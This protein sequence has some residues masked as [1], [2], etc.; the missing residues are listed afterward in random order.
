MIKIAHLAD[1]HF[2][3]EKIE[4][5]NIAL[6]SFRDE[7]RKNLVDLI[8]ISGDIWDGAVQ[9]TA[10][11]MFPFFVEHIQSLADIA[12]VVMIY[13]TPSH[14]TEGSLEVFQKIESE[15]GISILRPGAAYVLANGDVYHV[16]EAPGEK[17]DLLLF[18]VPEPS[19]KWLLANS[20]AVG[21]EAAAD[22]AAQ[23]L[24]NLFLGL[25]AKRKQNSD[26]PCLLLYH[27]RVRGATFSNG[28]ISDDG[29][30]T[31]TLTSVGANYYALGDIH[32]PQE[33]AP[34]AWYPGSL[35]ACNWGETHRPGWNLVQINADPAGSLGFDLAF[36]TRVTRVDFPLPEQVK[37]TVTL[38]G[39][40]STNW[41]PR[42]AG[43]KV[44]VEITGTKEDLAGLN[45]EYMAE[46]VLQGSYK[47]LPGSRVT[48]KADITETVR[49]AA[50][51]EKTR[52]R[53]K[54][55][56]W[57]EASGDKVEDRVIEKAD[58]LEEEARKSGVVTSAASIRI[59]KLVL[60]GAIGIWK[61]QR[62]EEV[63]LDLDNLDQGLIALVGVN[64]AGKTTLIE[65]LHPWP[66]L[67]T[68]SG[69]LQDHF[70]LRDS[71]RDLYFTDVKTGIAYRALL[72][73]DGK[74]KSGSVEY[75]LYQNTGNGFEPV[76]DING[77]KDPY[78][79]KVNDLFGSLQLY[80]KS[81]FISQR[82][83][84][85][86]PDFLDATPGG[87]EAALRRTRRNRL[88]G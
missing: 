56:L 50:I 34:N 74:N 61:G 52:L 53:D 71:F 48:L 84:K 86:S 57:A 16:D 66:Q 28:Q 43:R 58:A 68:R 72:Q 8:A 18:G 12:P 2:R 62:K 60:R 17:C 42:V 13:G 73:I 11:S 59:N 22:A 7:A 24:Q 23:A 81:A 82:P 88:P 70:C 38:E 4:D 55:E 35:Y 49:A 78:V 20:E 45:P 75:H 64:G 46:E 41:P 37:Y 14:D 6:A 44:W 65:N 19:K 26:L 27:G 1:L 54:V 51:T 33:V 79:E 21:K 9:N 36:D 63:V 83:S 39:F 77:R 80:L 40:D 32:E 76:P 85:S 3:R 25:A 29:V 30:N 31:D 15:Y 10:G 87:K 69:K 67:L 5:I 47:A